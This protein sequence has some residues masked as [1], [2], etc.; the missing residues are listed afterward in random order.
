[1]FFSKN[2]R[3]YIDRYFYDVINSETW[4]KCP[5]PLSCSILSSSNLYIESEVIVWTAFKRFVQG[6]EE[7]TGKFHLYMQQFFSVNTV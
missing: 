7:L 5:V 1:M 3:E 4:L 6:N 2:A